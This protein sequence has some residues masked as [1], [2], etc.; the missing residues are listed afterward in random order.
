METHF[1]WADE[2]GDLLTRER[3]TL[4][5]RQIDLSQLAENEWALVVC[6]GHP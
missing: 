1:A 3:Y 4:L 5:A 6:S 2:I